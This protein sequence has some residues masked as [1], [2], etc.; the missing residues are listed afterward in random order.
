MGGNIEVLAED[1]DIGGERSVV[2]C[3]C[4]SETA[5][6]FK[7]SRSRSNHF[8]STNFRGSGIGIDNVGAVL[9]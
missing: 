4:N 6:F 2:N 8:Q 9:Y 5:Q 3:D 7:N 1:G